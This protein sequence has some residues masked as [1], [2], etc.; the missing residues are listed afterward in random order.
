MEKHFCPTFIRKGDQ[1]AV[2]NYRRFSLLTSI[3]CYKVYSKIFIKKLKAQE[4]MLLWNAGLDSKRQILHRSIT[5]ANTH[6]GVDS[7]LY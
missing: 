6:F 2:K 5:L 1:Q 3:A 7:L 4:E